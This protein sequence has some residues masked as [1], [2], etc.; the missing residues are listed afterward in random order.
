MGRALD[1]KGALTRAGMSQAELSRRLDV[2]P[3]IVTGWASGKKHPSAWRL[4][5]IAAALGCTI[6]ELFAQDD[7]TA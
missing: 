2:S 6:D 3:A 1:L 7:L 5:E 4:P